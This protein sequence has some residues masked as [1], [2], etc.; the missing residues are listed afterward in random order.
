METAIASTA[1]GRSIPQLLET[2][3]A[4]RLSTWLQCRLKFYFRYV[5]GITT[6]PT[7]AIH[8]GKVVHAVLQHWNIN[9][10]RGIP[11]DDN[12]AKAVFAEEWGNAVCVDYQGKEEKLKQTALTLALAYINNPPV[13]V[14]QK[15]EAVECSLEADLAEHGLPTLVGVLDLVQSGSIID[16]KTA[17]TTPNPIQ[18]SQRHEIQST[19]YSLLYRANTGA[20]EAGIAFHHLIKVKTPKVVVTDFK[21]V[22]GVQINRLYRMLESYMSGLEREDF[23]PSP[24][25]SCMGC[26]YIRQCQRWTG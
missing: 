18:A 22:T 14:D 3:S 8:I 26:E 4:S 25:F 13:P 9:R 19:I 21:P 16:Y 1:G 20:T 2:V 24:G 23:V 6:A 17:A 5:E 12:A 10:W 7:P 11:F 15:P